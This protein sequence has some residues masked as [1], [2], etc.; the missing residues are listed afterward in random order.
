MGEAF[1]LRNKF[2]ILIH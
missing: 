1:V 2:C